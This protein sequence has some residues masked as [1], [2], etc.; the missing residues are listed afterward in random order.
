[1]APATSL[2]EARRLAL[3]A[4]QNLRD[5]E[6]DYA[7]ALASV[8]VAFSELRQA[9]AADSAEYRQQARLEASEQAEIDECGYTNM[10][11]SM[12]A[13]RQTCPL[14]QRSA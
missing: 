12:F 8:S 4:G 3:L 13:K 7:I 5:G 11:A 2:A 14:C 1:M 10:H 6:L 9:E